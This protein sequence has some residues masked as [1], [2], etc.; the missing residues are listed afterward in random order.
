MKPVD[1]LDCFILI[2]ILGRTYQA[3][4]KIIQHAAMAEQYIVDFLNVF[5]FISFR[6]SLVKL[7]QFSC[8]VRAAAALYPLSLS[9]HI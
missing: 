4:H 2:F 9:F 5:Y 6:Q 3:F 1:L 7:Q 8:T